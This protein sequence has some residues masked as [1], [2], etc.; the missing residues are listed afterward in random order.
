M[1]KVFG[2]IR[3]LAFIVEDIDAAMQTWAKR[4]G[5]GPFFIKREIQFED[6]FYRGKAAQ[7]P[8]TSIA[9]A[10]SGFIQIELVQQHCDT[11][12]IYKEHLDRGN[13]G[14]QHV[15][16]WVSTEEL[17]RLRTELPNQG[18]EL[19]QSCTIASSGV[20]LLYFSTEDDVGFIFEVADLKEADHYERI[21]GIKKAYDDW[22][23]EPLVIESAK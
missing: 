13:P 1:S 17:E 15:S 19:A 22:R 6:F 4:L 20:E 3:Q 12:S 11:P 2:E 18:Y 16:S 23:G 21:M 5:I 10:N 7:S 14:M 8:T 9:L